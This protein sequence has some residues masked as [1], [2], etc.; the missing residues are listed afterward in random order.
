MFLNF[1]QDNI[2]V[3]TSGTW[4]KVVQNPKNMIVKKIPL[5]ID[6]KWLKI[7]ISEKII[8]IAI[9]CKVQIYFNNHAFKRLPNLM[10]YS[11][12]Y[13]I[14]IHCPISILYEKFHSYDFMKNIWMRFFIQ[15]AYINLW[16]HKS[17][18]RKQYHLKGNKNCVWGF[19]SKIHF[20]WIL[21]C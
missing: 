16:I 11:I 4:N 1:Y 2:N 8:I 12:I 13:Y 3:F 19:V 14:W 10:K 17:L 20:M 18:L 7:Y 5:W 6:I 9:Y 15:Q 21:K